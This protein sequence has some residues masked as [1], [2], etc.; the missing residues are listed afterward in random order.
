MEK[1]KHFTVGIFDD[2]DVLLKAVREV[3]NRGVKIDEVYS[4][5]PVHGL[6]HALGYARSKMPIAAFFFGLTGTILA[7]LMQSL[8]MGVDWPMIIGGKPF[9][10]IPDFVPITFELTVLLSAFGMSFTFFFISDLKPHK[11][12]KIFDRRSTDDKHVMTIDLA[13]NR[14]GEEQINAVLKEVEAEEVYRKDFTDEENEGSF[15][16]YVVDLFTNGVTS[17]SRKLS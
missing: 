10:A 7:I 13:A 3:R 16:K 4:P 8:M 6:E 5:F 17:S 12:P 14:M 11:V 15:I 9:I 2:Q 1:N